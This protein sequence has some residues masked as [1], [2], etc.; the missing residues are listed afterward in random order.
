[1]DQHI[2]QAEDALFAYGFFHRWA[3]DKIDAYRNDYMDKKVKT[4]TG[5]PFR[6]VKFSAA[7][8]SVIHAA[9]SKPILLSDIINMLPGGSVSP[10]VIRVWRVE[11][12]FKEMVESLKNEYA[13]CCAERLLFGSP[14][15]LPVFYPLT[16]LRRLRGKLFF[17][18]EILAYPPELIDR[19][20][21]ALAAYHSHRNHP[22]ILWTDLSTV[23]Y[24][25]WAV[26]LLDL[27]KEK[28]ITPRKKKALREALPRMVPPRLS[29]GGDWLQPEHYQADLDQVALGYREKIGEIVKYIP[30]EPDGA[31]GWTKADR[32]IATNFLVGRYK[33]ASQPLEVD[34]DWELDTTLTWV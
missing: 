18:R 19:I 11:G 28:T 30:I 6:P 4:S 27:V 10:S 32:H 26:G 8:W 20:S 7:V 34:P 2:T 24:C 1:M 25:V 22:K 23:T 12:R 33:L 17:M 3:L 13:Q 29:T 14:E 5:R 16:S 9:Q 15:F 31:D 21:A